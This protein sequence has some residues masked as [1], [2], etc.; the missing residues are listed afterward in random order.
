MHLVEL[1]HRSS[2]QVPVV[3]CIARHFLSTRGVS[4]LLHVSKHREIRGDR[5]SSLLY[6]LEEPFRLVVSYLVT[7]CAVLDEYSLAFYVDYIA[8]VVCWLL[9]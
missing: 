5:L 7:G 2:T 6:F 9:P 4:Y 3:S 1:C 8:I